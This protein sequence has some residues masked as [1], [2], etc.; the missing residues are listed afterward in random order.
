[1]K[2]IFYLPAVLLSVFYASF[3]SAQSFIVSFPDTIAYGPAMAGTALTCWTNDLVTNIS[4]DSLVIDIIRVEDDTATPGW[5]SA[6]CFQACQAP[7]IDSLRATMAPSEVVNMAA[8]FIITDIPDS[9]TILMKIKNV[10]NPA[11][12][13]YQRFYGISQSST[14]ISEPVDFK[15]DVK[16]YP[17]PM[18]C[19]K[20]FSMF[21]S[22]DKFH[23][24]DISL[25]VYNI[26]G[27]KLTCINNLNSG[28]N[29]LNF[30]FPSGAYFF[31][32]TSKG[33]II[34]SGKLIFAD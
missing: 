27:S 7:F 30:N 2:N 29:T 16:V 15:K 14:G 34:G 19:G 28:L 31:S 21:I 4:G 8:H 24:N 17:L 20:D 6:F 9:G 33:K 10:S 26:Y 5:S 23:F 18:Q 22:T 11:D 12:V 13:I 3:S 25:S 1:M 32:I